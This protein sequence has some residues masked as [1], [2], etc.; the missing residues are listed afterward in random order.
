LAKGG[1]ETAFFV[2]LLRG[3][4]SLKTQKMRFLSLE[5]PM[6]SGLVFLNILIIF[7]LSDKK[8]NQRINILRFF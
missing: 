5:I 8:K 1:Q 2:P 4:R 6:V 3:Y 7:V